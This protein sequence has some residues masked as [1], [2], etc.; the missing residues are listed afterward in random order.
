MSKQDDKYQIII[1]SFNHGYTMFVFE[2]WAF[3]KNDRSL[4]Y[5]DNFAKFTEKSL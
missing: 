1:H 4:L 5:T 3:C 2:R